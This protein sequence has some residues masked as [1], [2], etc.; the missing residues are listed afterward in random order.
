MFKMV[1][2][3]TDL[4]EE[5]LF[6]KL[7]FR[8]RHAD[9]PYYFSVE[10]YDWTEGVV[11]FTRLDCAPAPIFKVGVA[12]NCLVVSSTYQHEVKSWL[13]GWDIAFKILEE[14]EIDSPEKARSFL[15]QLRNI[16]LTAKGRKTAGTRVK[17]AIDRFNRDVDRELMSLPGIMCKP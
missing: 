10:N 17:K 11:I 14:K 15:R 5:N 7:V 1:L 16:P 6:L 3:R 9:I 2:L 4:I 8:G 12:G 13:R